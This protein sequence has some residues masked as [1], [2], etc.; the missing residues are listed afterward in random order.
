MRKAK[1]QFTT[2]AHTVTGEPFYWAIDDTPPGNAHP[3]CLID[4]STN[5]SDESLAEFARRERHRQE[6]LER[7]TQITKQRNR[8]R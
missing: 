5:H 2:Y 4:G 8:R 6:C 1:T 7:R 3:C